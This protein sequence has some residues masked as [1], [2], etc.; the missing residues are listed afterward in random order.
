M[1]VT[2]HQEENAVNGEVVV[3]ATPDQLLANAP[4]DIKE[5]DVHDVFGGLTVRVRA[6]TAAQSAHVK[7]LSF[8]LQGR[9]PDLAWAQMEIAQFEIGVIQPKLTH[10]QVLMLHRTAGVSFTR[11]IEVIDR[12]TGI[13]KEELRSAQQEFQ[14]ERQSS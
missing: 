4:K 3:Y 6:L 1:S 9:G 13:S 10:Q 11:V 5:E 7:Q 8:T 12:I 2:E 14:E